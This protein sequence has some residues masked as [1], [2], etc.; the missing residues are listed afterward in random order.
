MSDEI[1]EP[2]RVAQK[3]LMVTWGFP[4]VM[5]GSSQIATSLARQFSSEEM[6]VVAEKWPGL[7]NNEWNDE[8]GEKPTVYFIH[9]QWPWKFK[10]TFRLFALPIVL[11]RLRRVFKRSKAK[12]ILA[13][14]PC[15]YYLYLSWIMARWYRVP[16]FSYFHNTYLENRNG[17]KRLFASWLQSRVFRDSAVVFVM[18]EGMKTV[19][20]QKHPSIEFVPLVHTFEQL[21]QRLPREPEA[22]P[23]FSL[24]FMGSLNQSNRE[25]FFRIGAVLRH[26]PKCSFTTYSENA[27][28]DFDSIAVAGKSIRHTRVAFDDVVTALRNHDLLF[29]PHGFRG[30]LTEIEYETIFPTRTIPYLLSGIPI[31]AHS[32]PNAFLT[33][34]LQKNDCAEVVV[35]PDEQALIA[36][37]E[38]LID[39]PSRCRQLSENAQQAAS[40]FYGPAVIKQLKDQLNSPKYLRP[41]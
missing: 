2:N 25:A 31:I 23:G 22:N 13:M 41:I 26:F 5:L 9:K 29:F 40:S 32:P 17:I 35:T 6:V 39:N 21:P 24:A 30:G 36:A 19:L 38:R 15:E 10:R 37:F 7:P 27:A 20:T 3:T 34:W 33:R 14:F 1:S 18:S 16:L 4:P 12:Q 11:W 8:C 28:V